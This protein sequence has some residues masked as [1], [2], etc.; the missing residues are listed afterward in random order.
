MRMLKL[1][2]KRRMRKSVVLREW[3][4]MR[5][6][7]RPRALLLLLLC[8]SARGPCPAWSSLGCL[9]VNEGLLPGS[10]GQGARSLEPNERRV[11]RRRQQ[12]RTGART[13]NCTSRRESNTKARSSHLSLLCATCTLG[14][15]LHQPKGLRGREAV[16]A[17]D[18]AEGNDRSRI[19]LVQGGLLR[20]D[21][22]IDGKEQDRRTESV[23]QFRAVKGR[24]CRKTHRSREAGWLVEAAQCQRCDWTTR[25]SS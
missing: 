9:I 16:V 5:E 22:Q 8:L 24:G 7:E 11:E 4:G 19:P 6:D 2:W 23:V 15:L 20:E 1:I 10:G 14:I 13:T 18:E 12:Q 25:C 21:L 17:A 3:D